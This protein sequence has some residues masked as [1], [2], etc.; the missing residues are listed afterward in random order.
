MSNDYQFTF[1]D[2]VVRFDIVGEERGICLSVGEATPHHKVSYRYKF[3]LSEFTVDDIKLMGSG[4]FYLPLLPYD[5]K[6]N[7]DNKFVIKLAQ[8]ETKYPAEVV[9][10]LIAPKSSDSDIEDL[11]F[12]NIDEFMEELRKFE[13]R[14][15]GTTDSSWLWF[16]S[17]EDKGKAILEMLKTRVTIE[18]AGLKFVSEIKDENLITEL[19][20]ISRNLGCV[21]IWTEMILKN[22]PQQMLGNNT[23]CDFIHFN[24]NAFEY[25]I[26]EKSKNDIIFLLD[27]WKQE[28]DRETIEKL[29]G[30]ELKRYIISIFDLGDK[31]N[32]DQFRQSMNYTGSGYVNL[33]MGGHN[34]YSK[35]LI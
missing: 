35:N 2:D 3:P 21:R 20:D 7:S 1:D 18:M 23:I 8:L 9:C 19:L 13:K 32:N 29:S 14:V 28:C 24:I 11:K 16:A 6:P 4:K 26:R 33:K 27:R 17:Q 12:E 30:D 25:C 5:G 22:P 15:A 31:E 10:I 34:F